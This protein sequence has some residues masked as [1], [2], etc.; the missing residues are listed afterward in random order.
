[1]VVHTYNSS[2]STN[3]DRRIMGQ[4]QLG[5]I[6]MRPYLKNKNYKQKDWRLGSS[7]REL[8]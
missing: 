8:A 1:M 7:D 2:Y 4:G 3:R 6:N 5:K